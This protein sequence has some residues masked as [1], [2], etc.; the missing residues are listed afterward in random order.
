MGNSLE[1]EM[2]ISPG[3]DLARIGLG[4]PPKALLETGKASPSEPG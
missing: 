1:G 4:A 2:P 3:W